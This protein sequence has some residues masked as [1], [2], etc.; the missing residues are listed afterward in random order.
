MLP[1]AITLGFSGPRKWFDPTDYPS[2]DE[3]AFAR[4]VENWLVDCLR[5]IPT[6]LHLGPQHFIC[7]ISQIA[8]GADMAFT[9][10]CQR[11][12]FPQQIFLPQHRDAY[13]DA[14]GPEGESDFPGHRKSEALTLLASPHIIHERVASDAPNRETRFEETNIEL[15]RSSDVLLCLVREGAVGRPGG[16]RDVVERASKLGKPVLLITVDISGSKPTFRERWLQA[17]D[18]PRFIPPVLP[19]EV[20]NLHVAGPP[21]ILPD[22]EAFLEVVMAHCD[23][24]AM[25]HSRFFKSAALIIVGTHCLAT[26]CAVAA[27]KVTAEKFY[28]LLLAF[29]GIEV[30][31]LLTGFLVHH[32]LHH[33]AAA[34]DWAFYR[35]LAEISRSVLSLKDCHMVLEHLHALPLPPAL[36]SYL[37]TIEILHLQASR[38]TEKDT[39]LQSRAQYT[40]NRLAGQVSFYQRECTKAA[41]LQRRAQKFF[42]WSSGSAILATSLK[43]TFAVSHISPFGVGTADWKTLLGFLAVVLPVSAVAVLSLAAANDLQAR[44]HTFGEMLDFLQIQQNRLRLAASRR[45]FTRIVMETESRL[46]GETVNWFSRRSFTGVA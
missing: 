1:T 2:I 36:H 33:R 5:R 27:L 6:E 31:L 18:V 17:T 34:S 28:P 21:G 3:K 14:T 44:Q 8:I 19:T 16:T 20:A 39:W 22:V 13:L 29:L 41:R 24:H 37:R 23:Q 15:I 32:H 10:A 40:S 11:L 4:D 26:V 9:R 7:A 25:R 35:L 46:L 42:L 45:D 12:T 30:M 38:N 43:L